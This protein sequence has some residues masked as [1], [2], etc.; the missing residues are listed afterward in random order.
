MAI[1][2]RLHASMVSISDANRGLHLVCNKERYHFRPR[3]KILLKRVVP[4]EILISY[5]ISAYHLEE[6]Y[7]VGNGG[8]WLQCVESRVKS[9]ILLNSNI[10]MSGSH[11]PSPLEI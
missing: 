1:K 5:S 10:C 8:L 11:T 2:H 3:L 7:R 9:L 6:K 4:L